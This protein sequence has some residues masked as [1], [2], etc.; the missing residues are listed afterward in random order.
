MAP[1]AG[2]THRFFSTQGTHS[3][4]VM[5]LGLRNVILHVTGLYHEVWC[6]KGPP[7][8]FLCLTVV[9]QIP[10]SST[11]VPP[12]SFCLPNTPLIAF[13]L[14]S[15]T[16]KCLSLWLHD[17]QSVFLC[18]PM[19][20]DLIFCSAQGLAHAIQYIPGISKVL[21]PSVQGFPLHFGA[22]EA[23]KA[24][25]MQPRCLQACLCI[26]NGP[27]AVFVFDH[28]DEGVEHALATSVDYT[29]LEEVLDL[30]EGRKALQEDLDRLDRWAEANRMSFNKAKYWLLHFGYN[31]PMHQ[32]PH[33]WLEDCVEEKDLQMLVVS[34]LNMSQQ[35][36]WVAKKTSGILACIR[37]GVAGRSREVIIPLYSVSQVFS[38]GSLTTRKS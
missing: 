32:S 23:S 26:H 35:C 27:P 37:N 18:S 2:E 4:C 29:K 19:T 38:F 20:C 5:S 22:P 31:H 28:L 8:A 24:P 15:G 12:N 7:V 30:L 13:I 34:Q 36:A 9:S 1:L 17:S 3:G 6:I 21:V 33:P 11:Q 16:S 25:S 14:H 10:C